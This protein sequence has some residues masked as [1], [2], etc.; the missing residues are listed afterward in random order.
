MAKG[1]YEPLTPILH[2]E[3]L[4]SCMSD[5]S[6]TPKSPLLPGESQ[7]RCQ[8]SPKV[9]LTL[10]AAVLL[11][12]TMLVPYVMGVTSGHIMPI[13]PMVSDGGVCPPESYVFSSLLVF[14]VITLLALAWHL[15]P[16]VQADPVKPP[17]QRR[18]R[19]GRLVFLLV[20]SVA[21]L[22]VAAWDES[23]ESFG[24]HLSASV[25]FPC[26][27]GFSWC[28]ALL[29]PQREPCLRWFRVGMAC[30]QTLCCFIVAGVFSVEL[31]NETSVGGGLKGLCNATGKTLDIKCFYQR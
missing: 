12:L 20:S 13:L 25:M 9:L 22:G 6:A 4:D 24:H 16:S 31:G 27:V 23:H 28:V 18:L 2:S 26:A 7:R 15:R 3:S 17:A 1:H 29:T 21:G 11:F 10:L 30:V 5:S 19:I 8:A 14:T